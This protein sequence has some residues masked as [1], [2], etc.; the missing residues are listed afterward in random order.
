MFDL[1]RRSSTKPLRTLTHHDY[2]YTLAAALSASSLFAIFLPLS[3]ATGLSL[4]QLNAGTGFSYFPIG[5]GPLLLQPLALALG[6]RPVYVG[7]AFV[8]AGVVLW[9]PSAT[10][11][12]QWV[13]NRLLFGFF[14]S[15]S[16]AM[17]EVSISDV[18]SA[19]RGDQW[20]GADHV[21]KFFL[22]ERGVP[23]GFY[24]LF[25]YLGATLAPLLGGFI[26]NGLG[27]QAVLASRSSRKPYRS[28]GLPSSFAVHERRIQRTRRP[29]PL[30]LPRGDQL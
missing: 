25:L 20:N 19:L 18:V 14:G 27:W 10:G 12:G 24:I 17:V 23:M 28:K 22:H 30:L 9:M 2:R 21:S 15:P 11:Y 26:F 7:T 3:E 8:I 16:F 13:A 4:E 1:V 5:F 6:K 29:V